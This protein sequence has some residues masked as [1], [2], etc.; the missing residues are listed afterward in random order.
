MLPRIDAGKLKFGS[1][2]SLTLSEW[3]KLYNNFDFYKPKF[4]LRPQAISNT[5]EVIRRLGVI[6]MNT[7]VEVDIYGHANSTH[8][9]STRLVNGIGGSRDFLRNGYISIIHY[10][11]SRNIT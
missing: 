5:L 1:A 8:I 3:D 7:L 9:N 4:I 6:A 11:S 2:T 10:P